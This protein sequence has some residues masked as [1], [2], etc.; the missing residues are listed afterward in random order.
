MEWI[1]VEDRLPEVGVWVLAYYMG[2]PVPFIGKRT[3]RYRT[4]WTDYE[5]GE[6]GTPTHWMPIPAYPQKEEFAGLPEHQNP[7]DWSA[8]DAQA[9]KLT[10]YVGV[11]TAPTGERHAY[12]ISDSEEDD[13]SQADDS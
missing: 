13:G 2:A 11:L 6:R 12:P 10:G 8:D 5:I 1:S 7:I 3:G 9:P 4:H